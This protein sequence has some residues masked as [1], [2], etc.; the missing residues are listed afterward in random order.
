MCGREKSR[1]NQDKWMCLWVF[2][3]T[4]D[5]REEEGG[6]GRTEETK[7]GKETRHSKIIDGGWRQCVI[8]QMRVGRW[9]SRGGGGGQ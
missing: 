5:C 1:L 2:L 6:G 7:G 4:V 3:A 8:M 9:S